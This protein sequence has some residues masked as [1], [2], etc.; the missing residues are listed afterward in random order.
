MGE[1]KQTAIDVYVRLQAVYVELGAIEAKME[2]M[3]FHHISLAD[4]RQARQTILEVVEEDEALQEIHKQ[5]YKG[6][7]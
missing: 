3:R 6:W 5:L 1:V 2:E 4:I 7:V